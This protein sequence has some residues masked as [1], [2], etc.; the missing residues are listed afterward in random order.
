MSTITTPEQ[1]GQVVSITVAPTGTM[2]AGVASQMTLTVTYDNGNVQTAT[3]SVPPGAQGLGGSGIYFFDGVPTTTAFPSAMS[4]DLVINSVD[5]G[6]WRFDGT[7]WNFTGSYLRAQKDRD[8]ITNISVNQKNITT[9]YPATDGGGVINIKSRQWPI[10]VANPISSISSYYGYM[11]PNWQGVEMD[12]LGVRAVQR[13]YANTRMRDQTLQRR[14][15]LI[16][17]E[18]LGTT[19]GQLAVLFTS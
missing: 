13:A 16:L 17:Q 19:L 11:G 12:R 2:T 8:Q 3:F 14:K 1:G 6:V 4:G 10:D 7:N 18:E 15:A 5:T 9:N